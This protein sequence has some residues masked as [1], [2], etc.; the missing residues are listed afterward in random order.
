MSPG[1][2]SLFSRSGLSACWE[3]DHATIS[4]ESVNIAG[5]GAPIRTM[6]EVFIFRDLRIV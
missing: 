4:Y 2:A 1:D 3:A 5:V 6:M